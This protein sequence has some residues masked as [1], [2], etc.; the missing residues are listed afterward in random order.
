MH[1]AQN[2]SPRQ[3]TDIARVIHKILAQRP[4]LV[5]ATFCRPNVSATAGKLYALR[6][7]ETS[8]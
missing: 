3:L 5:S 4:S 2:N 6:E 1:E 7:T 8:T